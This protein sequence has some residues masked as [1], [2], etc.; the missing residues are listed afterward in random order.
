M[1]I[2]S[3]DGWWR[4]TPGYKH[5]F[6]I[7][8]LRAIEHRRAIAR[9]ANTGKSGFISARGDVGQT[10]GWEQRGVITAEVPLNSELTFY[11]RYGDCL[12]RISEYILLLSVLYYVAYRYKRRNHLVK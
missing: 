2:T 4:D 12:A 8:R 7:S 1:A 5:L 6:T 11:T 3:N 9:S 10:L